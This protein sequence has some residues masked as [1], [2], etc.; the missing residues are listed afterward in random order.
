MQSQLFSFINIQWAQQIG[1]KSGKSQGNALTKLTTYWWSFTLPNKMTCNMLEPDPWAERTTCG[2]THFSP[3]KL[4]FYREQNIRLKIVICNEIVS[5][6]NKLLFWSKFWCFPTVIRVGSI[7]HILAQVPFLNIMCI[8][9]CTKSWVK[10]VIE[11]IC[12]L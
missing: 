2:I 7:E 8:I 5:S 1:V 11:H 4:K 6:F 12:S 9:I 3:P 10:I